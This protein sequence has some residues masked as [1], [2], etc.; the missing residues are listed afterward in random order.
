MDFLMLQKKRNKIPFRVMLPMLF[1]LMMV[2]ISC[3]TKWSLPTATNSDSTFS[4]GVANYI[5]ISPDWSSDNGFSFQSPRDIISGRDGYL[6]VA[7]QSG[8]SISVL[9]ASG[10]I[11]TTDAFGND[12]S[13]LANLPFEPI[14]IAQDS[15]LNLFI[16]DSSNRIWVWNQYINNVGIQAIIT[17]IQFHNIGW[18]SDLDSIAAL[19][20]TTPADTVLTTTEGIVNLMGIHPFWDGN[21]PLDSIN[22]ARYYIGADTIRF[23]GVSNGPDAQDFA[24]AADAASNSVVRFTYTPKAL[25]VTNDDQVTF[26]YRGV[27]TQRPASRG[28]GNGTVNT[29][30]GMCTDL[31]GGI[32]YTQWGPI[33]GMHK[34][35]GSGAFDLGVDP[36][37]DLNR[38]NHPSDVTVD[39]TGNIYIAD[40]DN[41]QIQQF[42]RQGN[43]TYFVGV[44]KVRVDTT[45]IHST[46][47][48]TG[49]IYTSVD[50][51]IDKFSADILNRPA[52]VAVDAG[53]VVYIAD[54]GNN[55]VM[56][57]KLSTDFNY[58]QPQ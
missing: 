23:T 54:T 18:V 42:D 33:F 36:I 58:Q 21:D 10:A 4:A 50:T 11:I 44:S 52:G 22:A 43:F 16:A 53:N 49:W 55:R 34:V 30:K 57:F 7:N 3:G 38:F 28:S 45:I 26:L 37:M 9:D 56:R 25:V 2:T 17:A 20:S 32:Y 13:V 29:P 15:R 14:A 40:T 27:I 24:Y 1:A 41:N 47:S 19:I 5:R 46:L 51:V 31:E 35:G 8:R 48:D 6:F 39:Q 12:F